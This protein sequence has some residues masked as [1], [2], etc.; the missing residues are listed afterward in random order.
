MEDENRI[1]H[2]YNSFIIYIYLRGL[3]LQKLYNLDMCKFSSGCASIDSM[4]CKACG[5]K[6]CKQ[7]HRSLKTGNPPPTGNSA[8]CP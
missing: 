6:L 4:N 3:Y 8:N 1:D 7:C 2:K 5:C